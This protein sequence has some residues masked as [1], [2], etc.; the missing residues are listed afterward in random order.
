M[1]SCFL[2]YVHQSND[3]I[4]VYLVYISFP[5]FIQFHAVLYL[6]PIMCIKRPLMSIIVVQ[7]QILVGFVPITY[8]LWGLPLKKN[9]SSMDQPTL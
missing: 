7:I 5:I 8:Q 1:I 3:R 2:S 4:N 9:I 6:Y